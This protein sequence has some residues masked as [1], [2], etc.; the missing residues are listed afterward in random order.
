MFAETFA[1]PEDTKLRYIKKSLIIDFLRKIVTQVGNPA[2][3][4]DLKNNL[5]KTGKLV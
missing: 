4:N 3:S 5:V 1:D 2:V